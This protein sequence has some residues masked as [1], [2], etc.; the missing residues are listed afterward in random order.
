MNDNTELLEL[1]KKLNAVSKELSRLYLYEAGLN[2]YADSIASYESLEENRKLVLAAEYVKTN[3]DLPVREREQLAYLAP[4]YKTHL[5]AL[6][7][8]HI[9]KIKAMTKKEILLAKIQLYQT[10]IS[11]QRARINLQ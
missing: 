10:L 6:K 1:E 3:L 7:L 9:E 4:A 2:A 5:E 8:A 11:T